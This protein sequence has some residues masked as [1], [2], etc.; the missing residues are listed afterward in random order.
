M[1]TTKISNLRPGLR[2]LTLRV[3][4]LGQTDVREVTSRKDG[5]SHRVAEERVGD[6]S[7]TILLTLWDD[8]IG[9]VEEGKTYEI[10]NAYTSVFKN[11]LRLNV[12]GYSEIKEAEKGIESVDESNDMSEKYF[13]QPPRSRFRSG[14]RRW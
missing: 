6:E 5:S 13:E 14:R 4:A 7:G 11:N 2:N 8:N 1:E 12:R 10:T 3:K 9:E